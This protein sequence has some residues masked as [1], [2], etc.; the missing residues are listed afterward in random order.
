MG[1]TPLPLTVHKIFASEKTTLCRPRR[2][3]GRLPV[4][5]DLPRSSNATEKIPL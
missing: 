1:S 4:E 5:S 2:P 3:P